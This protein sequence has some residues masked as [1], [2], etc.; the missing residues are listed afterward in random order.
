MS[1]VLEAKNVTKNFG[2]NG[3]TTEVLHDI[4]L[5]L[6]EGEFVAIVGFSGT[7]K[8]TLIN[9]LGGLE[10]PTSGTARPRKTPADSAPSRGQYDPP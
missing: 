9:L 6:E 2:H 8:T 4:N 5:S 1:L 7:G 10:M 3:H